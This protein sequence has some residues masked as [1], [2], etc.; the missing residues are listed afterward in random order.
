MSNILLLD[1]GLGT[2]LQRRGLRPGEAPDLF[3]LRA[4]EVVRGVHR[5]YF[6]AGSMM[7]RLGRLLSLISQKAR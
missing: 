6:E 1:G 7:V 4:P 3:T 5:E 2:M